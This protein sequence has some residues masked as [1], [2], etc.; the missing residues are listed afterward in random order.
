QTLAVTTVILFQV[1]YVMNCRSLSGSVFSIGFFSN[2]WV[3]VGVG[4]IVLLQLGFIFLPPLN[5]IFSS[6]PIGLRE[7]ALAALVG[8]SIIPVISLE[9]MWRGQGKPS[10]TG[11]AQT[12]P[13][14]TGRAPTQ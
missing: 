3:F 10:S 13:P 14:E 4:V 9:K 5:V 1:F 8:S 7:I 12:E 2:P 11:A 6:S